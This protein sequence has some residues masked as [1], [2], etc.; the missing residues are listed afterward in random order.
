[1]GRINH[2]WDF[3]YWQILQKGKNK[4]MEDDII[5]KMM[6]GIGEDQQFY[7]ITEFISKYNYEKLINHR[8]SM[9][10]FP[11][12]ELPVLLFD[13]NQMIIPL[14]RGTKILFDQFNTEQKEQVENFHK[15]LYLH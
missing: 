11:Y 13:E 14:V 10:I 5:Y 7:E 9:K 8:Y 2:V 4:M 1:M 3:E 6:I 15:K 12:A